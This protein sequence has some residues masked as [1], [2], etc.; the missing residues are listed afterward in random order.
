MSAS[1]LR[2]AVVG[3]GSIGREFALE[4][5]GRTTQTRVVAICDLDLKAAAA[6]ASDVSALYSGGRLGGSKYREIVSGGGAVSEANR[7]PVAKHRVQARG[8]VLEAVQL[9]H[10]DVASARSRGGIACEQKCVHAQVMHD[11]DQQ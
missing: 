4:H 11:D 2:V 7:V 1:P 3:A 6:L 5:F 9:H 8:N 10:L